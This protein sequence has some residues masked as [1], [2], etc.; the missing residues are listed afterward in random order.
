MYIFKVQSSS[1]RQ[2]PCEECCFGTRDRTVMGRGERM[3]WFRRSFEAAFAWLDTR[4]RHSCVLRF[5]HEWADEVHPT[6]DR[7]SASSSL[8]P[9]LVESRCTGRSTMARNGRGSTARSD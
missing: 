1:R 2:A 7:G 6:S 5:D 4:C 3:W 8:D 9:S